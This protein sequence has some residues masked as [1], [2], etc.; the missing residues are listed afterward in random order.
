V[1]GRTVSPHDLR[2]TCA[3]RSLRGGNASV[4]HLRKLLGHSAITTTQRYLDHLANA[5][6]RGIVPPPPGLA[7]AT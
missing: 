6:L 4:E 2:H 3:I 7:Q 1:R 5:E